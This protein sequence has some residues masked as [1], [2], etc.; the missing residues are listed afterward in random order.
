MFLSDEG[1]VLETLEFAFYIGHIHQLIDTQCEI[2]LL[3]ATLSSIHLQISIFVNPNSPGN[4]VVHSV[5]YSF[6]HSFIY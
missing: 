5:V 1:A 6:I 2:F 4:E 3:N